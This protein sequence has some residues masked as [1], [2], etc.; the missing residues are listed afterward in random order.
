MKVLSIKEPFATLIK[1]KKKHIETRSWKT[2]YRGE[3]YIHA[4]L[5]KIG[6][7]I[8]GRIELIHLISNDEM[9]YGNIICKC[10]LVDCIE[11]TEEYINKIKNEEPQEF[12]CGQYSSGRYAWILKNI[13]PLIK[14]IP[15][16]GQLGIWNYE[17]DKIKK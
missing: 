12:I 9:N 7:S 15:A 3:I 1:N 4:S 10:Q 6:N 11:M 8:D 16:R 17:L 14:P 5:T 13:E 2:N